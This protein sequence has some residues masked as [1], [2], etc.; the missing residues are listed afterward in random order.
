MRMPSTKVSGTRT[1][2]NQTMQKLIIIDVGITIMLLKRE[3]I[4]Y[5][6]ML[7]DPDSIYECLSGR[8]VDVLVSTNS[9][10]MKAYVFKTNKVHKQDYMSVVVR[11]DEDIE[12]LRHHINNAYGCYLV[13]V[14]HGGP[15]GENREARLRELNRYF[16]AV[17]QHRMLRGDRE[18]FAFLFIQETMKPEKSK[19]E[20]FLERLVDLSRQYLN[21][22]LTR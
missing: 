13:P 18:L 16:K 5:D 19:Y 8:T 9:H 2:D 7:D 4:N 12:N 1:H 21:R 11:S 3:T 6:E 22:M 14:L 20:R 17:L 15:E 10:H